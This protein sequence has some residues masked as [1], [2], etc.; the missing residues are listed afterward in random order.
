MHYAQVTRNS[1]PSQAR[2]SRSSRLSSQNLKISSFQIY[3]AITQ[4]LLQPSQ[5]KNFDM[6]SWVRAWFTTFAYA[7]KTAT[8]PWVST[9]RHCWPYCSTDNDIFSCHLATPLRCT[10]SSHS[11]PWILCKLPP[12][13]LTTTLFPP[14]VHESVRTPDSNRSSG[15]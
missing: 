4:L 7:P 14:Q 1:T 13:F 8:S 15:C 12:R 10:D 3:L 9:S 6:A 2:S 11:A 5:A